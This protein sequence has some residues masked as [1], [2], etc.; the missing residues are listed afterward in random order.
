MTNDELLAESTP[1]SQRV[2]RTVAKS[3]GP[4]LEAGDV[5]QDLYEWSVDHIHKVRE[6]L[7]PPTIVNDLDLLNEAEIAE[8]KRIGKNKLNRAYTNRAR[9]F[10]NKVKAETLGYRVSDLYWYS[11]ASVEEML[12][13]MFNY[14]NWMPTG[15]NDGTPRAPASP[16]EGNNW[17]ALMCDMKSGFETGSIEDR[18]LLTEKFWYGVDN[19]VMAVTQGVTETT[20]ER[21]LGRALGRMVERL[22]G[23]KPSEVKAKVAK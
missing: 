8:L 15:S 16:A 9:G 14:D 1:M 10:A 22:G 23:T 3:F 6:Y 13:M 12:P 21:R 19:K 5:Q 4:Y 2:A 17:L 11:R 20:I 18:D 7:D